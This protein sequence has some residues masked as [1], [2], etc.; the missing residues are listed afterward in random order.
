M[1]TDQQL[2]A[3]TRVPT[4]TSPQ[5]YRRAGISFRVSYG[6]LRLGTGA[7]ARLRAVDPE[8]TRSSPYQSAP[9]YGT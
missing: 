9:W 6:L 8:L 2:W 5:K 3:L 4:L 1:G 7:T